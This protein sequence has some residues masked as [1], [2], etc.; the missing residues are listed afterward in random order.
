MNEFSLE[1]FRPLLFNRVAFVPVYSNHLR[2]LDQKKGTTVAAA[3]NTLAGRET[4]ILK[5]NQSSPPASRLHLSDELFSGGNAVIAVFELPFPSPVHRGNVCVM[6]KR[7]SGVRR[8][9]VPSLRATQSSTSPIGVN[10]YNH[11]VMDNVIIRVPISRA[12]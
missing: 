11:N 1:S 10:L 4:N 9:A 8:A 6:L 7:P 3:S 2:C 12:V 5:P